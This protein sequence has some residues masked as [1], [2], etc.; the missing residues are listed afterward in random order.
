MGKITKRVLILISVLTLSN[1]A[2]ADITGLITNPGG[3]QGEGQYN[4]NFIF[5]GTSY[6]VYSTSTGKLNILTPPQGTTTNLAT[7]CSSATH[8]GRIMLSTSSTTGQWVY[9]CESSG[10]W[11]QQ[12]GSGNGMTPNATYY[13]NVTN[14]LQSGATFYVSSGTALN[15]NVS[16][17]GVTH[18]ATF[19]NVS[20][21]NWSNISTFSVSGNAIIDF[22]L[23]NSTTAGQYGF[24]LPQS[25]DCS[26][27]T[28]EGQLCWDSDDDI[29]YIAG[30]VPKGLIMNR[31]TLQANT[32]FYVSSGTALNFSASTITVT[33]LRVSSIT[34]NDFTANRSTIT[35]LN[36]ATLTATNG[37]FTN[38][39]ITNL[40][41]TNSTSTFLNAT[42]F[43]VTVATASRLH[44]TGSF[45]AKAVSDN[46]V[47]T[48]TDIGRV[49]YASQ[50]NSTSIGPS[51]TFVNALSTPLAAGDWHISGCALFDTASAASP[52]NSCQLAISIFSGNTT[53]D[54]VVGDNFL[55]AP[56][57][58]TTANIPICIPDVRFTV[59]TSTTVFLK[60]T[61]NYGGSAPRART[62]V[63]GFSIR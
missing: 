61:A 52:F 8:I 24:I 42:D 21:T 17:L 57:S 51:D 45:R 60:V 40:T 16:T 7:Y 25:T 41:A 36:S 18:Q 56:G 30:S 54:H 11:V 12:G 55:T 23:I 63:S 14:T 50:P 4:N 34:L 46:S 38:G 35:T 39:S 9:V 1:L 48:S 44:V 22:S 2:R 27:M 43:T 62:R 29:L 33:S 19:S 6:V 59:A 13:V 58:T 28:Q 49:L 32:T 10:N 37:V 15:L 5:D 31:N 20:L 53:T 47:A 3:N 26:L